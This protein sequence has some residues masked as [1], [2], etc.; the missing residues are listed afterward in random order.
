MA[1]GLNDREKAAVDKAILKIYRDAKNDQP[2]LSDMYAALKDL[3]QM[4][5]CEKLEKYISGTLSEVF[6]SPTNIKL[7]NRL[8]VFDIKDLPET[9][10]PIMMLIVANFVNNQVKA[11][12]EKRLLVIDEG[13]ILLKHQESADF[14][15]NMVRRARKYYLGVSIITQQADDFL[16][17]QNGQAIV[18]NCALRILL[19][20]DSTSIEKVAKHFRLSSKEERSLQT[21]GTGH[22]LI[23]ADE[24]HAFAHIRAAEAEDELITTDPKKRKKAVNTKTEE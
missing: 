20:Q 9:L 2:L 15:A 8:V 7:D 5:L 14:V 3:G 19:K 1:E 22:A 4:V 6:N 24:Q 18:S 11:D 21:A 17:S 13:W 12:P 16:E 10:R 23:I